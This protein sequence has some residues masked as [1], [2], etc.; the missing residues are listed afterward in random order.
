MSNLVQVNDG[1]L[2]KLIVGSGI[3]LSSNLGQLFLNSRSLNRLA[4]I[5][6][7]VVSE[8]ITG[9]KDKL[10]QINDEWDKEDVISRVRLSSRLNYIFPFVELYSIGD[11]NN[12]RLASVFLN[13]V[14]N[15]GLNKQKCVVDFLHRLDP[16][17][18]KYLLS[19]GGV[20]SRSQY[21]E[22]KQRFVEECNRTL[23]VLEEL[24]ID[25][26]RRALCYAEEFEKNREGSAR[27]Y[28]HRTPTI[29]KIWSEKGFG[30]CSDL[31]LTSTRKSAELTN[32][33]FTAFENISEM[34]INLTDINYSIS[35]SRSMRKAIHSN[36]WREVGSSIKLL[37]K[38][39]GRNLSPTTDFY[40]KIINSDRDFIREI[41]LNLGANDIWFRAR[42]PVTSFT[43][44]NSIY[45]ADEEL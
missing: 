10:N 14:R 26:P 9:L 31:L 5:N 28:L 35:T 34:L 18:F 24:D 3:N 33:F 39:I 30:T 41:L 20:I 29:Y 4:S 43:A 37:P 42:R 7:D 17:L 11:V 38:I 6:P 16:K 15:K 44:M 21:C 40:N 23:P 36:R 1:R 2:E 12:V 8:R 45:L 19:V 13:E 27:T 22:S 32:Y 25:L